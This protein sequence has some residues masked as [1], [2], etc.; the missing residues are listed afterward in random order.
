MRKIKD[1]Q[2]LRAALAAGERRFRI[3][4]RRGAYSSKAITP[5]AD[6]RFY[7]TN[8]IDGC[9]L[10]LSGRQLYTRSNIGKAMGLGAFVAEEPDDY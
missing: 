3:L 4:L 7:V 2:A 9:A 1:V 10:R 8:H 5:C 6:G